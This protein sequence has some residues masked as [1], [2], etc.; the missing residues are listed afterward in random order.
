MTAMGVY[1][2]IKA[3]FQD[4]IVPELREI[5]GEIRGL[6]RKIDA[7]EARAT[8]KLDALGQKVDGLGTRLQL[9]LDAVGA[10]LTTRLSD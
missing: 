7:M 9:K 6:C 5:G 1:E 4:I 10:R 2:Q 3:A 8:V